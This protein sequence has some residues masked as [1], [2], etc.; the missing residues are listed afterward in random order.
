MDTDGS[1][2]LSFG[3]AA[4]YRDRESLDNLAGVDA[5]HVR[6]QHAIAPAVDYQ[7]HKGALVASAES[8]FQRPKRRLVD[9]HF[10]AGFARGGL[11]QADR[12]EGRLAED[13]RRDIGVVDR[14]RPA[15]EE[16]VGDSA[17]F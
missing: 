14:D 10:A 5:E 4:F 15:T 8:M 16:R 2:E 13:C 17:P 6:T 9:I 7:L 12:A 11:G 3:R 1:V